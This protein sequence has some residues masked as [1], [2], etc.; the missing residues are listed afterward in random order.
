MDLCEWNNQ[1]VMYFNWGEQGNDNGLALAVA[2]M[3]LSA[4]LQSWF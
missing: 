1:T 3:P 4:F 2:D